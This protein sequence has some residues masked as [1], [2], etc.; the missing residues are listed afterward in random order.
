MGHRICWSI[1]KRFLKKKVKMRFWGI[2]K[3]IS[4]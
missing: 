1:H 3:T 4:H 2:V